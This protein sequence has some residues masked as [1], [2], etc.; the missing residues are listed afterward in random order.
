M[1]HRREFEPRR[2]PAFKADVITITPQVNP[3]H[4]TP[5]PS[6]AGVISVRTEHFGYTEILKAV[7][8]SIL[9]LKLCF[10]SYLRRFILN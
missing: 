10:S 5:V 7:V 8:W 9:P 6:G 2:S 3:R 4:A 1:A